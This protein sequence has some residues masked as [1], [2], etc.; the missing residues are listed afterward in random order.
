MNFKKI[1]LTLSIVLLCTVFSFAQ[2]VQVVVEVTNVVIN[3]G[4]VHCAV[5]FNADEFKREEP[6]IAFELDSTS[7][8]LTYVVTLPP[9]E[10]VVSAFQDRNGNMECDFRGLFPTELVAISNYSGRGFPSRNFNRQ[11]VLINSATGRVSIGLYM[12]R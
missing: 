6:T 9:G 1:I 7:A 4:K 5:F 10:Y 11:K 12:L 3:D 2:N 8:V